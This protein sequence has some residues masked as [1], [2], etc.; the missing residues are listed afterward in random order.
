MF[1]KDKSI[2][3]MKQ[4][5]KLTAVKV[6]PTLVFKEKISIEIDKSSMHVIFFFPV[7]L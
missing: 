3:N 2:I 7:A 1:I 5:G 6:G 4:I